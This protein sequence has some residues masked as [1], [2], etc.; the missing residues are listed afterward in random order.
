MSDPADTQQD[1]APEPS[2]TCQLNIIAATP[3]VLWQETRN[4]CDDALRQGH[5]FVMIL[6]GMEAFADER[7]LV[8]EDRQRAAR[9]RKIGDRH[10]FVLGRN[11]VHHLVR[12]RGSSTPCTFSVG[13]HGKPFLPDAPAYNLSH[14]GCWVVCAVSRDES[15]GVDVE[16]FARLK[17]YRELL[18]AVTHPTERRYIEQA[19]SDRRLALFKRCWTRK[20]AIL[21]AT[22][23]GLRDDLQAIDV[24]LERNEPVL[25]RPTPLRL[26][27]LTSDQDEATIALALSP[28]I[29]G[30]V[31]MFVSEPR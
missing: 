3:T 12:P 13:P 19:P 18:A 6:H 23:E 27:H 30:V 20:E 26:M 11:L 31:A 8:D 25:D 24:C 29:T 1:T 10:N 4:V 5:A 7:V 22:G 17:D 14:S 15:I 16:T 28:S 2:G 9:Y 21:K